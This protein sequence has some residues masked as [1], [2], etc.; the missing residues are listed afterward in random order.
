MVSAGEG[1]LYDFLWL[2]PDKSVYVLQNKIYP[3][4]KS[5]YADIGYVSN[6]T[7]NFQDTAGAQFK[8]GY[9]FTEEWAVE[10]DYMQ[11]Q[12]S[13]NTAF[14]SVGVINGAEPFVRRPLSNASVFIIWSPFY[15]KINTFNEIYYFDWS[16]GAGT[17]QYNMESSLQSN[18][19]SPNDP[20][21]Y[22]RETFTPIQL[23]TNL[24][25]HIN[26]HIHLGLEFL[27]TN[28]QASTPKNPGTDKWQ[29]N[30]DLVFSIGVS[31]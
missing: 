12:N 23:K 2:D 30:N 22:E 13:D 10:F 19:D 28:Y 4:N 16:F 15:G 18:I 6:L 25:F 5:F 29:Q 1:D 3:K 21:S 14:D 24:K 31:F 17:G 8:A 27:N 11:Y 20:N 9:Y 26:Q 7:S